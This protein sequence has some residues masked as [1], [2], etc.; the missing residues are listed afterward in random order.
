MG[1][2]LHPLAAILRRYAFAYTA[3]HDFA[4][5]STGGTASG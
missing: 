5:C 4:V 2:G 1:E 3:A